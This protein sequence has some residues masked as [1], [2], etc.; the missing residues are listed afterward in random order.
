MKKL[1]LAAVAVS[2]S[3]CTATMA[4]YKATVID[5]TARAECKL[6]EYNVPFMTCV[7]D[8]KAAIKEDLK[9]AK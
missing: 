1:L 2:L 9:P 3:G 5:A 4:E 6:Q 7:K 8:T